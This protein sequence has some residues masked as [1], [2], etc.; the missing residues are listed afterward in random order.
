MPILSD[1]L[2]IAENLFFR[3]G[4]SGRVRSEHSFVAGGAEASPALISIPTIVL[5]P[6]G[7]PDD[8]L[9][10]SFRYLTPEAGVSLGGIWVRR[11]AS[12]FSN[13]A[14]TISQRQTLWTISNFGA[15]GRIGGRLLITA[16]SGRRGDFFS[17]AGP[18]VLHFHQRA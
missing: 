5:G 9:F 2:V 10:V 18:I 6:V 11:V 1:Y 16:S 8:L 7:D 12:D 17:L 15:G 14:E 3:F 4:S 13:L